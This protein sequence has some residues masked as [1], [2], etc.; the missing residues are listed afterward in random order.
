MAYLNSPSYIAL[1]QILQ[2]VPPTGDVDDSYPDQSTQEQVST[3]VCACERLGLIA[4]A[5]VNLADGKWAL[6][7]QPLRTGVTSGRALVPELTFRLLTW[8]SASTEAEWPEWEREV[9]L[10]D[11]VQN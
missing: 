3:S 8:I 1:A 4:M 11:K 10:K 6:L 5:D 2:E 9:G 7:R